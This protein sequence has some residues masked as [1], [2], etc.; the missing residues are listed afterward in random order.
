MDNAKMKLDGVLTL[1]L[2]KA[3]GEV[4]T[5]SKHN[6]I[7][8][9]GYDFICDAMCKGSGRPGVM[10]YIG[11]GS[12]TTAAAATQTALVSEIARNIATY[13]H[14]A[15]TKTFTVS[16]TFAAGQAT[17]AI[18]EA[19]V[20]NANTGGTMLDRVTFSV[21]NKGAEDTLTAKFTFTLS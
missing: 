15:G 21:I 19:G 5:F 8:N 3:N 16:A 12:G 18:T 1:T 2:N 11:L 13:A 4:I 14:V 10:A 17:G 7:V 6:M 9:V 20:F